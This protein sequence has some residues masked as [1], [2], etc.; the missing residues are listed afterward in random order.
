MPKI[1]REPI[2][3]FGLLAVGLFVYFQLTAAPEPEGSDDGIIEISAADAALLANQHSQAWSRPPTREE[4]DGLIQA[5]IRE[6]V[7]V[8]EALALGLDTGDGVIRNRLRQ[9][10]QFLT[11][12]AAQALTPEAPVLQAHLEANAERFEQAGTLA[13][14]QVLLGSNPTEDEVKATLNDL[15]SGADPLTRGVASMLPSQVQASAPVQIDGGFGRGF[16][17]ALAEFPI[18]EWSGPVRSGFGLHLIRLTEKEASRLPDLAEVEGKVLFDWR[19]EQAN[20]L[21]EA[22]F[23][24]LLT[25]YEIQIPSGDELNALVVQ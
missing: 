21:S 12:S 19:R 4:L 7:L 2:V 23:N 8:R 5:R 16:S 20:A 9:K 13:F 6:E 17:S 22:Q 24:A 11:D 10:M 1:L 25:A 14:E 18:G 3:H 15:R